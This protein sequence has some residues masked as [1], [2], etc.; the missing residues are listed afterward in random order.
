MN[1]LREY[2]TFITANAIAQTLEGDAEKWEEILNQVD[3][4]GL[5]HLQIEV[6]N[7]LKSTLKIYIE[8]S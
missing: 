8:I 2:Q 4:T 1:T 6:L 7:Q 5:T 3:V